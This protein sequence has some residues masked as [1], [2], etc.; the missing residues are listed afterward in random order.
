MRKAKGLMKNFLIVGL[1]L[2]SLNG[3][4]LPT[5]AYLY[6]PEDMTVDNGIVAILNNSNNYDASDGTF[7]GYEIYYRIY[8]S[9]IDASTML[10][11][12][13][14]LKSSYADAPDSFMNAATGSGYKFARLRNSYNNTAPL[15]PVAISMDIY[16]YLTLNGNSDWALTDANNEP[17]F[18]TATEAAQKRNLVIRNIT[19]T[20]TSQ[21]S[22]Y[23][24]YYQTDEADY[25]GST[26]GT[27]DEYYIV[28]FGVAY[29]T[30][31][32]T[33]G[34]PVYSMPFIPTNYA[35]Y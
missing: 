28:F 19:V 26:A 20:G 4:G 13:E 3:C 31:Q 9:P 29:G 25:A 16:Y 12:L 33:I 24:K 8:Q 21:T 32:T 14:S 2:F 27:S 23:R 7:L 11:K 30:D 35:K 6:P 15:I 1:A 5:V 18:G 17:L 10:T 22:F 34:Q